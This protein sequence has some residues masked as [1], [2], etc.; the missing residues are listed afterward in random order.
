LL[1]LLL[2]DSLRNG[3]PISYLCSKT[4]W[5]HDDAQLATPFCS[6]V[7]LPAACK[8]CQLQPWSHHTH[9][10][11]HIHRGQLQPLTAALSLSLYLFPCALP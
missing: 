11:R 7:I 6:L 8:V 2:L 9:R 5:H 1:L 10:F 3:A 4:P